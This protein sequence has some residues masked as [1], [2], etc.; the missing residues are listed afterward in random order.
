MKHELHRVTLTVEM[1]VCADAYDAVDT[2][3]SCVRHL[4]RLAGEWKACSAEPVLPGDEVD[5]D[6]M[7]WA[8]GN[9]ETIGDILDRMA[10]AYKATA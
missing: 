4:D 9:D 6:A 3:K 7:P 10:G 8:S 1:I 2:A 5:R